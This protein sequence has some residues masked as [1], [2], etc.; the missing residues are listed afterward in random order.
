MLQLVKDA[1]AWIDDRVAFVVAASFVLGSIVGVAMK[2]A[3]KG[4]Y[5]EKERAAEGAGQ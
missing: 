1:L 2:I 3:R 5:E 4:K